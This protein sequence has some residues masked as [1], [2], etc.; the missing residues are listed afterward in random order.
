MA[1]LD[2]RIYEEWRERAHG[3][4]GLRET[5]GDMP[6]ERL[7]QQIWFHQRIRRDDL[8]TLDGKRVRVGH[9]GFWNKEPGP[10]F[11]NAIIHIGDAPAQIGDI[12]IDLQTSGWRGHGHATNP[13]Y[14][15]VI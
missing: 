11:K 5:R 14:R 2:P 6:P 1:L 4:N 9:P 15:N 10:D 8:R 7:L 3:R 12:E 13:N